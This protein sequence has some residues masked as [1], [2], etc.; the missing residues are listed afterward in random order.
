MPHDAYVLAVRAAGHGLRDPRLLRTRHEVVDEHAVPTLLRR[1]IVAQDVAEQV[2]PVET[3]DDDP[4][5]AQVVAPDLLHE[6]GIVAAF[7]EDAARPGDPGSGCGGRERSRCGPTR[8]LRAGR[9]RRDEHDGP[10]LEQEPRAEGEQPRASMTVLELHQA[11]GDADDGTAVAVLGALDDQIPSRRH[12][13]QRGRR[14]LA[15]SGGEHVRS[16]PILHV[17]LRSVRRP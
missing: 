6:L 13:G 14:A 9:D 4:L 2:D 10:P 3:L 11:P 1:R 15:P 17:R 5:R 16:V 7:H 8:P 12:A